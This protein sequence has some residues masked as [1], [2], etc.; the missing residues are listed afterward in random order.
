MMA[1]EQCSPFRKMSVTRHVIALA[2]TNHRAGFPSHLRYPD[3]MASTIDRYLTFPSQPALLYSPF[4]TPAVRTNK[5]TE[6]PPLRTQHAGR[7]T[8]SR[9]FLGRHVFTWLHNFSPRILRERRQW[10]GGINSGTENSFIYSLARG[11]LD[12]IPRVRA[13]EG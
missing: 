2:I 3:R 13:R 5:H 1:R 10:N 6:P 7:G 11:A 8:P 9:R 4:M 12:G